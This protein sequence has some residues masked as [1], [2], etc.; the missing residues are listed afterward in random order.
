VFIFVAIF[1]I[2][3]KRGAVTIAKNQPFLLFLILGLFF[4]FLSYAVGIEIV[5]LTGTPNPL[6]TLLP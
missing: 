4:L 1:L 6:E 2:L 5:D 3:K